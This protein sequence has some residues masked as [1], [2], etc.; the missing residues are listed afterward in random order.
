MLLF[1]RRAD[2]SFYDVF[3]QIKT[4]P[5]DVSDICDDVD[6]VKVRGKSPRSARRAKANS[7]SG[8][9]RRRSELLI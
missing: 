6:L 4:V 7:V 5:I 8:G 1:A 2:S 3:L 9:A